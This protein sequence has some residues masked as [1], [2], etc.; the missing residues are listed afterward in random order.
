ME[1]IEKVKEKIFFNDEHIDKALHEI[2]V[3]YPN[4]VVSRKDIEG[5]CNFMKITSDD[6]LKAFYE[7]QRR[8]SEHVSEDLFHEMLSVL[9]SIRSPSVFRVL[10]KYIDL[11]FF[12][13]Q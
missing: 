3:Q 8:G 7:H 4:A 13:K 11:R 6:T 10:K 5:F 12:E 1:K 9:F 2:N